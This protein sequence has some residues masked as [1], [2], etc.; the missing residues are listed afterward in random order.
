[1]KI[2]CNEEG[3]QFLGEPISIVFSQHSNFVEKIMEIVKI[4]EKEFNQPT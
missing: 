1:M 4:K 2:P 3:A